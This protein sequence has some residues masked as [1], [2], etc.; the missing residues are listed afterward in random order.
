[1][2]KKEKSELKE[3]APLI[4]LFFTIIA[5]LIYLLVVMASQFKKDFNR[6]T[7]CDANNVYEHCPDLK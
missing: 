3:A 7:Y 5:A 6:W 2:N 1:M 4:L